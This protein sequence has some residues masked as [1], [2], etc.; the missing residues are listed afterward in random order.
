MKKIMVVDDNP[1]MISTVKRGLEA[2][3][4]GYTIIEAGTGKDCIELLEKGERPDIILLDIMMP[5]MDGWDTAAHIKSNRGW[6]NIPIVFLTAKT[7][8]IS[9]GIDKITSRDYIKKPFDL[10]DFRKRLDTILKI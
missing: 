8:N 10:F 2:L 6:K 3:S 5:D 9:T 4:A 7:D 1:D